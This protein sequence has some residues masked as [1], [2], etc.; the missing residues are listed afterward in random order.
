MT[1]Q[2][3]DVKPRRVTETHFERQN[4]HVIGPHTQMSATFVHFAK[5]YVV[6]HSTTERGVP[7]VTRVRAS[8]GDWQCPGRIV[9]S[10]GQN[11]GL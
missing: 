2:K 1:A 3:A 8:I 4:R 9:D 5:K 11:A 7:G 6:W 10:G